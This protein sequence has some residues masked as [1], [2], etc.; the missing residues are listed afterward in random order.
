MY[1][2]IQEWREGVYRGDKGN[3]ALR[4]RVTHPY[5]QKKATLL[6]LTILTFVKVQKHTFIFV[7]IFYALLLE[8]RSKSE[9]EWIIFRAKL[10]PE[11][12]TYEV[13]TNGFLFLFLFFICS[14]VRV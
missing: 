2:F 8:G 13:G 3:S 12:D 4:V 7:C 1:G 14:Q 9:L 5:M 11:A 10:V 6:H